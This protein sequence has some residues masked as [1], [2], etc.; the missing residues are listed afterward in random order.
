MY[1]KVLGIHFCYFREGHCTRTLITID[2]LQTTP[3]PPLLGEG[4]SSAIKPC[5]NPLVLVSC[6]AAPC[7][8][9]T[10]HPAH[11]YLWKLR[12][13]CL[14]DCLFFFL[15]GTKEKKRAKGILSW[16]LMKQRNLVQIKKKLMLTVSLHF[17]QIYM[18]REVC[19][20]ELKRD[21]TTSFD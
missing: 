11:G 8:Q 14:F 17:Y 20:C 9:S 21:G 15:W 13:F 12:F 2:N 10:G 6:K 3:P 16:I 19:F 7:P 18:F 4:R 1:F 5:R